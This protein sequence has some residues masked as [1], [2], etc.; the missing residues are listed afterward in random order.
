M[1]RWNVP[2]ALQSPNGIT[3]N[4]YSPCC[5]A[6]A[7]FS[8]SAGS[9]STC[10]Y[11]L[12]R[13]SVENHLAAPSASSVSSILGRG[14]ASFLVTWF[15]FRKSTQNRVD[16]SLFFTKTTGDDQGPWAGSMMF[17]DSIW[18]TRVCISPLRLKGSLLAGWR[19][20]AAFPV[21]M[22][23][24]TTP[25]HPRSP[26]PKEIA[27]SNSNRRDWRLSRSGLERSFVLDIMFCTASSRSFLGLLFSLSDYLRAQTPS[28]SDRGWRSTTFWFL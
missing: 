10:Q 12:A 7:V 26:S 1:R 8:R 22:W 20:G 15:T 19:I 24:F 3:R 16:P 11:P 18:L 23:C 6:K 2:G 5:V 25:V 21:S 14:W 4:W 13:S 27:S 28:T 9:T 17:L